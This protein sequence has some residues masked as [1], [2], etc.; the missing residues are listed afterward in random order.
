MPDVANA[1]FQAF[2]HW[3]VPNI[4]LSIHTRFALNLGS[5]HALKAQELPYVP[6]HPQQGSPYHRCV[7]FANRPRPDALRYTLF[8]LR[9]S[10]PLKIPGIAAMPRLGFDLRTFCAR[11]GLLYPAAPTS[12][13]EYPPL[14][15]DVQPGHRAWV[16]R[17]DPNEVEGGIPGGIRPGGTA[18]LPG[19]MG[20]RAARGGVP[21]GVRTGAGISGR[22]GGRGKEDEIGGGVFMFREEW[23]EE[24]RLFL[25]PVASVLMHWLGRRCRGSTGRFSVR[26]LLAGS[27]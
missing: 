13:I 20:G 4:P 22:S 8:L 10:V 2:A 18:G 26:A 14:P 23:D 7:P 19:P 25:S 15:P 5:R 1:T 16:G 6:P 9:Q 17:A 27:S 24:V 3:I 11:H 12:P 21:K